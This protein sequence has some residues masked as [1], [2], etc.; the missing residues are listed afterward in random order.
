MKKWIYIFGLVLFGVLSCK[1]A[2]NSASAENDGDGASMVTISFCKSNT[3]A[4]STTTPFETD[5]KFKCVDVFVFS[6]K[7]QNP[8][9]NPI[10]YVPDLLLNHYKYT[11]TYPATNL[12][13]SAPVRLATT[14]GRKFFLVVVNDHTNYDAMSLSTYEDVCN[15]FYSMSDKAQYMW[16]DGTV[17][18][19]DRGLLM[20]GL[21]EKFV[22]SG[23]NDVSISLKRQ[24]SRI[25]ITKIE[26]N[27]PSEYGSL[28]VKCVF[29]SNYVDQWPIGGASFVSGTPSYQDKYGINAHFKYDASDTSETPSVIDGIHV[30]PYNGLTC[31]SGELVIPTGGN[32]T[33]YAGKGLYAFPNSHQ[34][35]DWWRNNPDSWPSYPD[36]PVIWPTRVVMAASVDYF[37]D[38]IFYYA[39]TPSEQLKA[40]STYDISIKVNNLGTDSPESE[41]E[42]GTASFTVS[43]SDW[44]VVDETFVQ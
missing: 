13:P 42:I 21:T 6:D 23:E 22:S 24:C 12:D 19:R 29:L 30:F 34:D 15:V 10:V 33:L 43:A 9:A 14:R 7:E 16:Q 5:S 40:N 35:V 27:L 8:L 38:R 41:L 32:S 37:G 2:D 44:T 26:N 4:T 39:M 1:K 11:P 36:L 31:I 18:T 17:T 20:T 28:K 3:K 25:N